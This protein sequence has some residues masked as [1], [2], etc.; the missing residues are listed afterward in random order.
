MIDELDVVATQSPAAVPSRARPGFLAWSL[1]ALIVGAVVAVDPA[2]LVPTGPSRWTVITLATGCAIGALVLRP[3]TFPRLMTGLWVALLGVLLLATVRAVDPLSAWIGTPDRR[4]GLLAWVT[5]PALFLAG[6]ACTARAATRLVLRASTLA[7][8]VLGVWSAAEL[9]G[10]SPL[11]L[12]FANSR[13]GGPFGQPA[14][15]G[16][17]CVLLGPL[18]VATAL[19][20]DERTWWR[21][22]GALGVVAALVALAAS[23]TRAA[24]VG[25]IVAA[26]AI[27][28]AQRRVLIR[29]RARVPVAVVVGAIAI[30]IAIITPLGARATSSFDLHEGTSASRFDEW[31]TAT[32]TIADHPLLGVGPEGYRVVFPQEVRESYIEKYGVAVFPDRAHDGI[33]DVTLAG[34]VLAGLLYAA[35]LSLAVAHAWRGLRARDAISVALGAAVLAYIVQQLFLFP[36]AELDPILW[37]LVGMLVVRTPGSDRR[38]TVRARWLVVTVAIATAAALVYGARDVL[39]DRELKRA[40]NTADVRVALRDAD[41]ATRLRPDSIRAWYVAA[42]VAQRG[43]ALTDVDAALDRVLAGLDRS[44]RDPALRVL[45]GE[46]LVERAARSRLGVDIDLARRELARLVADAPHDPRLRKDL[47]TARSLHEIGKS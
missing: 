1:A 6:Y 4:L 3:I 44:P 40:A 18:S 32:R 43:E 23:Q 33:L 5:F 26:V 14:Y 36:L 10:H 7:A 13:A 15:L 21:R 35:L 16:A 9:L 11:G 2:G 46:L 28:V 42:R 22:A 37:V 41:E 8:V 47:V 25:A 19:D 34:G 20:A 30:A 27:A 17:A 12:E 39:A 29:Y 38:S 31:R 45:Y 24:W